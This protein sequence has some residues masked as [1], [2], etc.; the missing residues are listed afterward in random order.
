[1]IYCMKKNLF[2][3]KEKRFL[4]GKL[5]GQWIGRKGTNITFPL[6]S[7]LCSISRRERPLPLKP[8][9]RRRR[10]GRIMSSSLRRRSGAGGEEEEEE[11]EDFESEEEEEEGEEDPRPS[12]P[13][14]AARSRFGW[15]SS[16]P[17]P[18]NP[19]QSATSSSLASYAAGRIRGAA[20]TGEWK[21]LNFPGTTKLKRYWREIYRFWLLGKLGFLKKTFTTANLLFICRD[22]VFVAFFLRRAMMKSEVG[23]RIRLGK[24]EG[25]WLKKVEVP[26]L[27]LSSVPIFFFGEGAFFS[28]LLFY[29]KMRSV[30]VVKKKGKGWNYTLLACLFAA[31]VGGNPPSAAAPAATLS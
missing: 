16:T 10:S 31:A 2:R 26:P 29:A 13:I 15:T 25:T 21:A 17:P 14:P 1:M 18:P 22:V 27:F 24:R 3:W 7:P 12:V 6:L 8:K 23:S 28:F 4:N 30:A 5:Q 20:A 9:K 11:E 19:T